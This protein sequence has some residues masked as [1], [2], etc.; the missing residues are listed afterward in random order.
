MT[1]VISADQELSLGFKVRRLRLSQ[2]LT[3]QELAIL[4]GVSQ[5]EVS[6]L[7]NNLPLR[8]DAKR[9]LLKELWARRAAS[10]NGATLRWR[11]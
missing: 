3:T 9:K 4:A 6:L 2:L 8:L 1:P 7:E 11:Q 5:E 10:N